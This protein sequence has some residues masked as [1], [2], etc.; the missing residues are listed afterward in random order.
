[1]QCTPH[2]DFWIANKF[3]GNTLTAN[4]LNGDILQKCHLVLFNPIWNTWNVARCSCYSWPHWKGAQLVFFCSEF[5]SPLYNCSPLLLLSSI[6]KRDNDSTVQ[7]TKITLPQT[8]EIIKGRDKN[9]PEK[10]WINWIFIRSLFITNCELFYH[11][12]P[13]NKQ[14][15]R[16]VIFDLIQRF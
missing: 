10:H 3:V 13:N 16:V 14:L 12:N 1:M 11:I 15:N 7:C 4:K 8:A 5:F 2:S 9:G 6:S